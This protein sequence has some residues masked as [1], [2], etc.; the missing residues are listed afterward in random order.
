M[1]KCDICGKRADFIN[2]IK[3]SEFET[4]Q[5]CDDCLEDDDKVLNVVVCE[6]EDEE[7][8]NERK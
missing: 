7:S 5:V 1:R 6:L 3:V 4:A 2:I 8:S